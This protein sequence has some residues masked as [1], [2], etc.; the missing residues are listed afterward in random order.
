MR[1]ILPFLLCAISLSAQVPERKWSFDLHGLPATLEGDF[2]GTV[3]NQPIVL[4]LKNDLALG[5]DKTKP[6]ASIEYQGHRFGLTLSADAQDY[7]GSAILTRTISLD[8]KDYQ[9][10]TLVNSQIKLTSYDLNW[11]I[12]ALTWEQAWIGVDLGFHTWDLDMSA[13][14]DINSTPTTAAEK[15]PVPIPQLGLSFGGKAFGDRFVG[16]ASFHLLTYKGA[17]Y[18]RWQGDVR[19]FPLSWLGLRAFLDDESF[20]VPQNSVKDDLIFNLQRSGAGFGVVV[21]F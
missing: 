4:N 9:M 17:T 8:G 10:G 5:K 3:D 13:T 19:Y 15:I 21:R 11:T 18:H 1:S 20:D 6:G 14:G 16:R 7:V 2:Q 12:R